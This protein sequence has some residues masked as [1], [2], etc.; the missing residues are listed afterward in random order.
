MMILYTGS[1][2]NAN[3]AICEATWGTAEGNGTI[4]EAMLCTASSG[5][6]AYAIASVSPGVA[7]TSD[8]NLKITWEVPF[9]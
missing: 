5:G 8:F 6:N 2:V 9:E 1:V 3:R 7:K 4:T